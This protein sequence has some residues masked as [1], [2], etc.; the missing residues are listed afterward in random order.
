MQ[1]SFCTFV[2]ILTFILNF[3]V[4]SNGHRITNR[5][6]GKE[7]NMMDE[8]TSTTAMVQP[9]MQNTTLFSNAQFT[10][11]T[12]CKSKM[13]TQQE[14]AFLDNT[15]VHAFQQSKISIS[16]FDGDGPQYVQMIVRF[17]A[18]VLAAITRLCRFSFGMTHHPI[19]E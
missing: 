4:G 2:A 16:T 6:N 9:T 14:Q 18:L 7:E 13:M 8:T 12:R 1:L 19:L 10:F 17:F 15:M 3:I 11:S 5:S